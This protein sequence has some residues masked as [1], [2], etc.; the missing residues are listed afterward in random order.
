MQNAEKIRHLR[1]GFRNE[2]S[3]PDAENGRSDMSDRIRISNLKFEIS[4]ASDSFPVAMQLEKSP[5]GSP[6]ANRK[7]DSNKRTL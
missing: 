2:V 4:D 1:S 5:V 3:G 7:T 6:A